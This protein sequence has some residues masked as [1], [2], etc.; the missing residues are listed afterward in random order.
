[1]RSWHIHMAVMIEHRAH[2]YD[3][4]DTTNDEDET[5]YLDNM[6]TGALKACST[7]NDSSESICHFSQFKISLNA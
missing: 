2:K 3:D 1:L 7:S 6:P 4:H 5:N